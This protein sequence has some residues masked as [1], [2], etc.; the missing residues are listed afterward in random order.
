MSG[1]KGEGKLPPKK[2]KKGLEASSKKRWEEEEEE[3]EDTVSD[4]L[5]NKIKCVLLPS[6]LKRMDGLW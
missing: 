6:Q 3:E 2:K 5:S 1:K 4:L